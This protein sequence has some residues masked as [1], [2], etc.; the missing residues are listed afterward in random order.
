MAPFLVALQTGLSNQRF[1]RSNNVVA[2]LCSVNGLRSTCSC[3][4]QAATAVVLCPTVHTHNHVTIA[5]CG[6]NNTVSGS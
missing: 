1:S 2:V 6:P 4:S 3:A 5:C